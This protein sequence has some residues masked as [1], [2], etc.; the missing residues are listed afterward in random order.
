MKTDCIIIG[1]GH[2]G[3]TAAAYLAK[4]GCKVTVLEARNMVGGFCTTEE[5]VEKAPG[6]KCHPTSLDHILTKVEPSIVTELGLEKLGLQY[7]SLDPFYSYVRPDGFSLCFWRDYRQTVA[8]IAKFSKKDAKNY[9][10]LTR[11]LIGLW[12]VAFPY[13]M[14][15]PKRLSFRF[16]M[17]VLKS[18]LLSRADLAAGVRVFLMSPLEAITTYFESDE[19]RAALSCFAASI[20]YPLEY[21]GTGIILAMMAIQHGW[22]VYRP[23]GGGGQLPEALRRF[24]EQHGGQVLTSAIVEQIDLAGDKV[25]GVKLADGT[26]IKSAT[27]IGAISPQN[28]YNRLL[29]PGSLPE[30]VYEELAK[31]TAGS[32]NVGAYTA[33]LALSARPT[34]NVAPER[35]KDLHKSAVMTAESM[36]S[37]Q[38]WVQAANSGQLG[39]KLPAWFIMPSYWDRTLVPPESRGESI[40]VYLPAVTRQWRDGSSWAERGETIKNMAIDVYEKIAPGVKASVIGDFYVSP[41]DLSR[42]SY[43]TLGGPYHVDMTLS[44]MGPWRP[45]PSLSG[46]KSPIKGL[47]HTGAG[48]HPVGAINGWSGRTVAR[49]VRK[50][51]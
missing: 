49:M 48:A 47:Y 32:C 42:F 1:G 46:Y 16:I 39:E 27:V 10:E 31:I 3:L 29:P 20:F 30:K 21:P 44:H 11:A 41:D 38:Q 2:N 34:F 33:G 4:A 45:T 18:L 14:G 36:E 43:N 37:V 5:L 24:I 13:L 15:H 40:Y 50:Q 35:Q 7:I 12:Q 25:T 6:F 23:V 28:L 17:A 19:L 8:E 22:G 26:S 51:L 9:E